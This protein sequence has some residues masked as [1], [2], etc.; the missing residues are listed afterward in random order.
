[1]QRE[2]TK[3]THPSLVSIRGEIV[4]HLLRASGVSLKLSVT[5]IDHHYRKYKLIEGVTA[6]AFS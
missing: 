4:Y 2:W 6:M 3:Y 5:E 1:M